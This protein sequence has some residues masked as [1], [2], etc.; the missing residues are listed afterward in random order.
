MASSKRLAIKNH[1]SQRTPQEQ[2][3]VDHHN[4]ED[5]QHIIDTQHQVIVQMKNKQTI[6]KLCSILITIDDLS[7]DP[8]FSIHSTLLHSSCTRGRHNS[9]S[10]IVS[11]HNLL[12]YLNY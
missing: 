6:H 12:L 4:L 2:L 8:S 9:I 7:D 10:T 11:T 5:L 1:E 3:Y